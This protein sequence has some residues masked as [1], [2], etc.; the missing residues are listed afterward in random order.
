MSDKVHRGRDRIHGAHKDDPQY[1]EYVKLYL[2]GDRRG[3][4]EPWMV[5]F[6]LAEAELVAPSSITGS[7]EFSESGFRKIAAALSTLWMEGDDE[8]CDD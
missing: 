8:P 5:K 2:D 6:L 4:F 3:P 7:A 1:R